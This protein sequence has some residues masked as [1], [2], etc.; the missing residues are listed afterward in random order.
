MAWKKPEEELPSVS[1][2][3]GL[4]SQPPVQATRP[5]D[6]PRGSGGAVIGSS[7][8]IKGE[9]TGNEDLFIHGQVDG[10]VTLHKNAVVVGR[11]GRVKAD[12]YARSIRVE[13]QVSGDLYGEA[14]VIIHQTGQVRGNIT[15]PQVSL[16]NGS[17]FKGAIDMEPGDERGAAEGKADGKGKEPAVTSLSPQ[18]S[19]PT[20]LP[21]GTNKEAA[22]A[23]TRN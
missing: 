16:E 2:S 15:A 8:V 21:S 4:A 7:L 5:V 23:S 10:K 14:E 19:A 18:P 12:I 11:E 13:G 3:P 22:A 17:K 1:P 9:V 6:A 20:G